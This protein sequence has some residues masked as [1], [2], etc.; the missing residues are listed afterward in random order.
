MNRP[1]PLCGET[2]G[3]PW[4]EHPDGAVL[5]CDACEL[6]YVATLPDDP[7][8]TYVDNSSSRPSYYSAAERVDAISFG[9]RV[10]AIERFAN[11]G[12]MLDVGANVGNFVAAAR[13]R[14]WDCEGLE[15]N[16]QATET[17]RSKGLRV[18]RGFLEEF[19]ASANYDD[20]YD[21][22]HAGDVIEH[23][24]D[25][26][27]F[28]RLC[29]RL[30]RPGGLFVVVTPDMDLFLGRALQIK[31]RE[32]LVYFNPPTL[33]RTLTSAGFEV[34]G[35]QRGTRRRSIEAMIHSTT[36][37]PAGRRMLRLA[38]WPPVAETLSWALWR[39]TR[40]EAIAFARRPLGH[41]S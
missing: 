30:I 14:G 36:F 35:I 28:A 18:T 37:G 33:E 22:V 25:P 32:H 41:P 8:R 13:K 20:R 29:K 16:P 24:A 1:C 10:A 6:G 39:F 26:V 21:V 4:R 40:D 3:Q 17:A 2:K 23:T 34:L 5:R 27:A 9:S 31:P 11:K 7:R 12:K 38:S 15:P 19:A